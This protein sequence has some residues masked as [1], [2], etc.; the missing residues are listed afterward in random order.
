MALLR[1]KESPAQANKMK[2]RT[3]SRRRDNE[4]TMQWL[5]FRG[6]TLVPPATHC[7]SSRSSGIRSSRQH[8]QT[9]TS[10]PHEQHAKQ[11]TNIRQ[12]IRFRVPGPVQLRDA[13]LPRPWQP[14][15][16][17]QFY[18]LLSMTRN[19][20]FHTTCLN[21]CSTCLWPHGAC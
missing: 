17:A 18:K 15:S 13:R 11:S 12:L 20:C 16:F 2:S 1:D 5:E 7:S 3:H 8:W 6:K 4:E 21:P 10:W 14:E 9:K 19:T